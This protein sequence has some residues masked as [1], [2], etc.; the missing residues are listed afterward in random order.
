MNF[1]AL[2]LFKERMEELS[3]EEQFIKTALLFFGAKYELGTEN[4]RECDCSGLICGALT[5][6]GYKIRVNAHQILTRM[7]DFNN[8]NGKSVVLIGCMKDGL[9]KHVGIVLDGGED[10]VVLNSSHPTGVQIETY[11]SF[12]NR[13][14]KR[15][16]SVSTFSLDFDKVK[17]MEGVIYDLDEDLS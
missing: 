3:K 16:Y 10:T 17:A 2:S 11:D 5:L 14:I 9:Y 8:S 7:V 12:I 4:M 1:R 15:G 6:M 13:Y